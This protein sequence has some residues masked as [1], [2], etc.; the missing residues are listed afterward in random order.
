VCVATSL[1]N[2]A[3][4]EQ[5]HVTA[6]TVKH[7]VTAVMTKLDMSNRTQVAAWVL[8]QEV[9]LDAAEEAS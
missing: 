2:Q 9:D 6:D 8:Q 7:H 5:L 4:A 3:I 1:S